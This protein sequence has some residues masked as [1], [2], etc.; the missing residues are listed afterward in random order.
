MILAK[1]E[2]DFAKI[3]Q[4]FCEIRSVILVRSECDFV[5][6]QSPGLILVKSECDFGSV[7]LVKSECDFGKVRV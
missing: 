3:S 4:R 2:C 7:I 1:S 5:L 6:E